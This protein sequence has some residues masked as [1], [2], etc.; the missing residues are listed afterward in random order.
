MYYS[1]QSQKNLYL[2]ME[3]M[4]GGDLAS[5]LKN[6]NSFEEPMA[7]LYLAEVRS[8]TFVAFFSLAR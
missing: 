2:V 8:V 7:R 5:L 6:L 4:P 3:Y 1:F